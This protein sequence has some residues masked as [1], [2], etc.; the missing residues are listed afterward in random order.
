MGYKK[1]RGAKG[2]LLLDTRYNLAI[3]Y[4][5][6][7][8]L[9]DAAKHFKLIIKGYIEILGPSHPEMIKAFNHLERLQK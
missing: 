6:R 2:K 3:L 8:M 4:K 9:K 7:L 1:L 5:K